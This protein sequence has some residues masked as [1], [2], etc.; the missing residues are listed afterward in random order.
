[1]VKPNPGKKM[2]MS[3]VAIHETNKA[4]AKMLTLTT[5]CQM[6]NSLE[7]KKKALTREASKVLKK[8]AEG[9]LQSREQAGRSRVSRVGGMGGGGKMR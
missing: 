5:S 6:Y 7:E 3:D 2:L 4:H 1:M 9:K 8:R